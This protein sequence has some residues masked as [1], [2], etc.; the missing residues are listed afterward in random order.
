M[1][2]MWEREVLGSRRRTTLLVFE[3]EG[4]CGR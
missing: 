2:K 4:F 1:L 3:E